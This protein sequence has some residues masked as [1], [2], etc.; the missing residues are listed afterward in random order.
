[1]GILLVLVI[2]GF[3]GVRKCTS[4]R[5]SCKGWA[6][7]PEAQCLRGFAAVLQVFAGDSCGGAGTG[8]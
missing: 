2:L 7:V 1:M 6:K 4:A 3:V 5:G 8:V